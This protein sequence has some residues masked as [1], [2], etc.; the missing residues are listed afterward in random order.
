TAAKAG[1]IAPFGDAKGY[2]LGLAFEILVSTLTGS[3]LGT[4]VRGT[5]DS[6]S[7]C[8]KGDV[9]IVMNAAVG[10]GMV[11]PVTAY[12]EAIRAC[13]PVEGTAAVT[14]PGDRTHVCREQRLAQGI[15][16]AAEVWNR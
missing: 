10:A 11:K 16:I 5:L 4:D 7:P 15:P 14:V 6:S 9:F 3:A 13:A 1:A 2:A 12:L 8:N